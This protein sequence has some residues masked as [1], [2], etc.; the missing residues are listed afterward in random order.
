MSKDTIC[1][2]P[3]N[4]LA[5]L[6]NGDYGIC[7][8]CVYSAA[9]RLI[10]DGVSENVLTKDI[11]EVRNHPMYVDLR[12]SMMAGEKHPLC[13]LCW[14]EEELGILSKRQN[15][16]KIYGNT[17][18]Q[19]VNSEDKSGVIDT[20]EYPLNY[21][22]LRLGNLC[23]LKCRSCGPA[24]SSLWIEDMYDAGITEFRVQNISKSYEIEKKN[25]VYKIKS[26][27]FQYYAS[28]QFGKNLEE[29]LSTIDRIYFT[30]G[31]PLLN[32]KHYEILDYCIEH[33]Y[34]KN[35]T[36]EYNTNGTT[37]NKNL[38]EQWRHFAHV[39]VCFSIDGI[40]D[41]AHYV[42]YPSDWEVIEA[43]IKELD[44]SDLTNVLCTTNFTVSILNVKHFLE[45]L[46]WFYAQP[47]QKFG[48]RNRRLYWH[49]LVGPPWFNLQVLPQET[50]QE[51]TALYQKYMD[52]SPRSFIKSYI[53]PI[54]DF[55][56]AGDMSQYLPDT[57][58]VIE[59][60]DKIRN[61]KLEDYIPWLSD[62]LK[63]V[64]SNA[65]K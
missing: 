17:L 30:G 45:T 44:S 51:I 15:Q 26:D 38:L 14:D 62:V 19:I 53:G 48:G 47:F 58:R 42:R 49:R 59:G 61:Q 27:D 40:G 36:L 2:I 54:V 6:Q 46:D 43:N 5:I 52:E 41:M 3:W 10:T 12:R 63:N 35:I 55:M 7:C 24:D 64:E 13:K 9:G 22:D 60:I 50:K 8:Q 34:A 18:E 56:N 21:L 23:N 11:E 37:L 28:E 57:K 32:K 4:H 39:I 1:T 31:D 20:K 29:T 33:D 65:K 25:N 16:Q